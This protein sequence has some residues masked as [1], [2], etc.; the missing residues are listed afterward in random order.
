MVEGMR[1][2]YSE[3]DAKLWAYFT[4]GSCISQDSQDAGTTT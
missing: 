1:K 2:R 4:K 3:S